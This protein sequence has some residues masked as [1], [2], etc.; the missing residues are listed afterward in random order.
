MKIFS[1]IVLW[2]LVIIS[3]LFVFIGMMPIDNGTGNLAMVIGGGIFMAL[4][5]AIFKINN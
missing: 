4:G 3:S 2:L 5:I 1:K